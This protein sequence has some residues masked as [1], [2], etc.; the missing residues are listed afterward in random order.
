MS[1]YDNL[2]GMEEVLDEFAI[3]TAE[4][5][6]GVN[7]DLVNLESGGDDDL[8]NR[9][10][11]AFHTIKGTCGFLGF[12]QAKDVAHV[13]EDLLNQLRNGEIEP[14][15][16]MIDV[17]L[18]SSDWFGNFLE[19]V[20]ERQE[21][22]YEIEPL[23]ERLRAAN[24]GQAKEPEP[25]EQVEPAQV[26]SEQDQAVEGSQPVSEEELDA[27]ELSEASSDDS[28]AEQTEPLAVA[29]EAQPETQEAIETHIEP[30]TAPTEVDPH[31][32]MSGDS[33]HE[34]SSA[35]A[36]HSNDKPEKNGKT[37]A[38]NSSQTIRV[39]ME[40]LENLMNLAGELVLSRNQLGQAY[41]N[42]TVSRNG[43][44]SLDNLDQ[45]NNAMG[46]V[47]TEIQ[48]AVMQMRMLPI[49]NVFRRFPR[50][51]RDLAKLREKQVSLEL[52]GEETE[53]DRSV[54]ESIGDPLLHLVR[55]SVDH[56][57]ETPEDRKA[58]GKDPQG[59][60]TLR[61]SHEGNHIVIE[62]EDDGHGI[63]A[64]KLV[65]KAVEKGA[66]APSEAESMSYRE[67]LNLIF[68]AGFST[69]EQV[70][71]V[72]GRGV[73]MDVVHTNISKLNG[74]IDV[75]TRIG[76]GTRITIKLPL[77]LAI[78]TG[79]KVNVQDEEYIVPFTSIIETVKIGD[80]DLTQVENKWV[81][82]FRDAVVPTL[83]LDEWFQVPSKEN[84]HQERYAVIVAVAEFR[85]ALVVTGMQGQ[86]EAVI[87]PLGQALGRIPG[88]AGGTI[89]GDGL[90]T[91]ILDVPE[92]I[93]SMGMA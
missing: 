7:E 31:P 62:V 13:A 55:N 46:R 52:I 68:K 40:R 9:V 3:E 43:D 73:G 17:L 37:T 87:K 74:V 50:V 26:E 28:P 4:L 61:A 34:A 88:I 12:I 56:G 84:E 63:N 15:G 57:I 91:L 30:T 93:Y 32:E 90:I 1:V 27:T 48:E 54:I 39:D 14:H 16:G 70:T 92:L 42:L 65:A 78:V 72:S 33:S 20:K 59:K 69:A 75:D 82:R 35:T 44:A 79:L 53:L 19:D 49:S 86:E 45:V 58:A 77:T 11:R 81:I 36:D 25:A 41:T 38:S 6:E 66:L 2:V 24:N 64:D 47:T 5:L 60:V 8:V 10:F 67:K 80:E 83:F 71:D 85:Y 76:E 18:E 29:E 89:G 21:Q 23:L 51:V 22:E